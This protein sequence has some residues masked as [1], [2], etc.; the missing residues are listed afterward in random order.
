M[1]YYPNLNRWMNK[2]EMVIKSA[3]LFLGIKLTIGFEIKKQE[4]SKIGTKLKFQKE[5]V[6]YYF[7]LLMMRISF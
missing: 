4:I 7:K 1:K 5:N 6:V 2:K 3:I